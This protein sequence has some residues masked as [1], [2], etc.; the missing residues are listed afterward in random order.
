MRIEEDVLAQIGLHRDAD[1]P[2]VAHGP[3]RT[4][5]RPPQAPRLSSFSTPRRPGCTRMQHM[6]RR[7][8][9]APGSTFS[10]APPVEDWLAPMAYDLQ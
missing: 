7:A 5:K 8:R 2:R 1:S 6:E 10:G 4:A 9:N 3:Q